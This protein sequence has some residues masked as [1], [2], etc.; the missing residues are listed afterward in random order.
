M[1][2]APPVPTGEQGITSQ[3]GGRRPACSSK[4][5]RTAGS[6]LPADGQ[7]SANPQGTLAG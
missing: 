2:V 4:E 3:G 6:S 7:E 5:F 1:V